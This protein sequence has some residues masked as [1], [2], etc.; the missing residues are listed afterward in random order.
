MGSLAVRIAGVLAVCA[1]VAACNRNTPTAPSQPGSAP[2]AV[3][4]P[5]PAPAVPQPPPI[6]PGTEAPVASINSIMLNRPPDAPASL[7]IDVTGTTAS[8]GWSNPHL[9]ED[10]EAG[11]DPSVKSYR[12]VATSPAT[13]SRDQTP[14]MVDTEL[15]VD[16]LPPEVK[17]IRVISAG[18]EISAPIAE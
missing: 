17:S 1:A 14:Q 15:R 8:A 3:T 16:S 2:A 12:F 7:I 18:N 6:P 13:E 11:S 10:T 4:A 9:A 5:A